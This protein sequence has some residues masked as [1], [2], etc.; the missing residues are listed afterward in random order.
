MKRFLFGVFCLFLSGC[1]MHSAIDEVKTTEPVKPKVV[2]VSYNECS[3]DK[4]ILISKRTA[5]LLLPY[6]NEADVKTDIN[7]IYLHNSLHDI[8]CVK[9]SASQPAPKE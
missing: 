7:N 3:W 5:E 1:T 4:P 2:E 6:I 9:V 8:H